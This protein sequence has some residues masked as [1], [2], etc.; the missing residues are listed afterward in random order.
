[1]DIG[2]AITMPALL[3][4]LSA[5]C[6]FKQTDPTDKEEESENPSQDDS[7][8]AEEIQHNNGGVLG[9]NLKSGSEGKDSTINNS[10]PYYDS[11][12]ANTEK[13]PKEDSKEDSSRNLR[14]LNDT[15]NYSYIV[16]AHHL[17]PGVAALDN[18]SLYKN[19]MKKEG[20][21][22][23]AK[24]N[25]YTISCNI[26]YNVNGVHNGVWLP[27][28]YAIRAANGPLNKSWSA[29]SDD[30]QFNYRVAAMKIT[31]GRQFHDAHAAYN[32]SVRDTLD[33]IATAL[34]LHQDVCKPC[35][36]KA[37]GKIHPPYRLKTRL[38]AIS[39]WLRTK[40][41][42]GPASWTDP[43]YTSGPLAYEME[44]DRQKVL[45]AYHN[46]PS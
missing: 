40:V 18:S 10:F 30:F 27:G 8:G 33:K 29:T 25:S 16:A 20:S 13:Y 38:Y 2:E 19:Y 46:T 11:P 42:G 32:D 36:D 31:G 41:L 22:T 28:N 26:G 15:Q 39:K 6:P 35:F 43:Y 23:T 34:V 3:D 7:Q 14:V 24:G 12:G 44:D 4:E 5:E 45:D 21:C 37:N 9:D 17:I 1:M